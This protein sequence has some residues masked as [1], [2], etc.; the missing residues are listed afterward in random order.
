VQIY[1]LLVIV[2]CATEVQTWPKRKMWR[3]FAGLNGQ[4]HLNFNLN[5]WPN[6]LDGSITSCGLCGCWLSIN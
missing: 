5:V 4:M 2:P 6:T 1:A 3:Y